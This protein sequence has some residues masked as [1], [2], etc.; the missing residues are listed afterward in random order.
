[1]SHAETI[2]RIGKEV[3]QAQYLAEILDDRADRIYHELFLQ[4]EGSVEH[5]KAEAKQSKHYLEER[6][7]ARQAKRTWNEK[8]AE[9]KAAEVTFEEWRT[10]QANERAA[11]NAV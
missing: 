5:R 2:E 9:L 11:R 3:A 7:Q 4:A 1:M 6:R 10:I 8:K